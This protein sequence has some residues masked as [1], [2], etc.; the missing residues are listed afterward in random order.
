MINTCVDENAAEE[1][2]LGVYQP[3]DISKIPNWKYID[4]AL[5]KL[6]GRDDRTARCT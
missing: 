6:P 1:V 3:L 2:R 5:K 4:P